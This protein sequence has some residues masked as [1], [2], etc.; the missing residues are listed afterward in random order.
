MKSV[1]SA[2]QINTVSDLKG[3]WSVGVTQWAPLT[4]NVIPSLGS[5]AA[6]QALGDSSVTGNGLIMGFNWIGLG[7][8]DIN[9]IWAWVYGI[10]GCI[11]VGNLYGLGCIGFETGTDRIRKYWSLIG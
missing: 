1:H 6:N 5:V 3:V 8:L 10:L 4:S 9:N 11:C 2:R 7:G